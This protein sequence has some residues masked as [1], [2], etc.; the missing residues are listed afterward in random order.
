VQAIV[1]PITEKQAEYGRLVFETL[2]QQGVRVQL[3]DRSEKVGYKIRE[4]ETQKIP[5]ML[6]L[7]QKEVDTNTVSLRKHKEGDCG[8]HSVQSV[9]D[10]IKEKERTRG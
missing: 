7:G 6:V 1:L 10:E 8:V 9:V 4:A 3:D 5:Y 2:Q